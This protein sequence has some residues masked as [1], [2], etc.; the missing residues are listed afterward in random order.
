MIQ[1]ILTT[2]ATVSILVLS[3]IQMQDFCNTGTNPLA[4]YNSLKNT[5]AMSESISSDMVMP[6]LTHELGH[7]V[8]RDITYTQYIKTWGIKGENELK[9]RGAV[10]FSNLIWSP[11]LLQPN[12]LLF[13]KE[14]I[15]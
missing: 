6:I 13:L 11:K 3:P 7:A 12:E 2:L 4:C 14:S 5:I 10:A 9:E 8:L 1:L 15:K